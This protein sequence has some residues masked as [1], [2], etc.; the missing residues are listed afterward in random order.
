[1]TEGDDVTP[2]DVLDEISQWAAVLATMTSPANAAKELKKIAQQLS[3]LMVGT[4]AMQ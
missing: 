3:A 4:D 2:E 1:V